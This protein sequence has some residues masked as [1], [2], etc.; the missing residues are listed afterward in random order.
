M[1][2]TR[3]RI[4]VAV[5]LI[6]GCLAIGAAGAFAQQGPRQEL[7]QE[8]KPSSSNTARA[9]AASPEPAPPYIRQSRKMIVERLEQELAAATERVDRTTR[10]VKSSTD[11]EL[12]RARKT[13]DTLAGLLARIDAVLVEA[14]DEFPT[15]FDFTVAWSRTAAA[16]AN[17]QPQMQS[18]QGPCSSTSTSVTLWT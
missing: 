5:A 16:P 12:I 2:L 18:L 11:P 17:P 9:G 10:K 1:F 7:G 8:P 3:M 13:A 15:M 14:V 4:G 6:A